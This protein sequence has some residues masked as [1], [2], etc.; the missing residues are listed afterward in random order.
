MRHR[1]KLAIAALALCLPAAA[2]AGDGDKAPPERKICKTFE[3]TGSRMGR[4]RVCKTADEWKLE[5]VN[6]NK[7]LDDAQRDV[8]RQGY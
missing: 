4:V 2:Q 7:E 6:N 5:E 8:Q 3:K 1:F